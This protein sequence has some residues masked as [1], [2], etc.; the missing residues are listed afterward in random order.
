MILFVYSL[1][2]FHRIISCTELIHVM[3]TTKQ[4]N[5]LV[6]QVKEYFSMI[7]AES[8]VKHINYIYTSLC[9]VPLNIWKGDFPF[10]NNLK[11]WTQ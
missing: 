10:K 11:F 1:S 3:G 9:K 4:M 6:T 5:P 8:I 7:E 2:V